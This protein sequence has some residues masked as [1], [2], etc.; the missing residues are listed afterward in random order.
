[1]GASVV[2]DVDA[3]PV[4]EPAEHVFDLMAAAIDDSIVGDFNLAVRF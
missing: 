4:L 3:S 2:A 1:M